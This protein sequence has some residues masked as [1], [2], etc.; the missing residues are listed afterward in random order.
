MAKKTQ[1]AIRAKRA[2]DWRFPAEWEAQDA[3]I[4]AW[5]HADTD[6]APWLAQVERSYIS[7]AQSILSRSKL[8]LLVK[9]KALETRARRLID[10]E[11]LVSDAQL[12]C[13]R[14]DYDDTW[15]RDSGPITV[16]DTD[17]SMRWLDFHFT[18]WGGKYGAS[19]DDQIVAHLSKL[20]PFKHIEHIR[21]DFA[22]E[23]G[24]IET[25]GLG[26][27]LSTWNCL[28]KRH[29]EK[30]REQV[31]QALKANL[32][33]QRVLWLDEG[34]LQGDDTD[35]HIDT[36]ARFASPDCIVYQ[37]CS[38]PEDPH[39]APLQA[40]A[41]QLAELRQTDGSPY[42]LVALPWGEKITA[43]D[44]RRLAVSYANF[45]ILQGAVLMPGYE[46]DADVEASMKL[47]EAFP[48]HEILIVPCR[49]LIEQNGSLHCVTM[50]LPAGTLK[51]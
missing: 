21:V 46:L 34:E 3:V 33:V 26:T 30:S 11:G 18:G 43:E 6:W 48:N 22:L 7:L 4:L 28:S 36:L 50:Q 44:G 49:A 24:A 2:G 9:N 10:P 1:G 23:G 8:V 29:P 40:M 47:A 51:A 45:L 14:F 12:I 25:D 16:V 15:L 38:E 39:F 5:P 27:L 37:S 13:T 35:A 32:N 20:S 31:E 42:R 41:K 19:R 17:G